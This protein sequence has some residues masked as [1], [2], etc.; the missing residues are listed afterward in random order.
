[1]TLENYAANE[2]KNK[3]FEYLK[4]CQRGGSFRKRRKLYIKSQ[5]LIV[6]IN[7]NYAENWTVD[8]SIKVHVENEIV[9]VSRGNDLK[10]NNLLPLATQ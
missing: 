9:M 10:G 8:W 5:M 2:R 4:T 7:E 3:T 1:M 6:N